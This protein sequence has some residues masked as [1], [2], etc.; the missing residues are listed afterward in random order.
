MWG[1]VF[2][3]LPVQAGTLCFLSSLAAAGGEM[4]IWGKLLIVKLNC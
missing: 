1:G 3:L 2:L 4:G